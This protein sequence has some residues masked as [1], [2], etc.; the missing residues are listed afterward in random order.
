MICYDIKSQANPSQITRTLL[1][2]KDAD[3]T[4]VWQDATQTILI[5]FFPNPNCNP[6]RNPV[7]NPEPAKIITELYI[8]V[9]KFYSV[10]VKTCHGS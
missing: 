1:C 3:L 10:Q 8:N 9:L 2:A 4:I 6:G 5:L 7:P